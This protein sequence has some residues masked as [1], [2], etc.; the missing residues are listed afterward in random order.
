MRYYQGA[1]FVFLVCSPCAPAR[2]E[3]RHIWDALFTERSGGEDGTI[4]AEMPL[5]ELEFW[6]GGVAVLAE[7]VVTNVLASSQE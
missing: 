1:R 2:T 4:T 7:A 6:F 3:R 5:D